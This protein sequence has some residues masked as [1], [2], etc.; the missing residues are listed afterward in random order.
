MSRWTHV[1][2]LIRV[3][4]FS[5]FRQQTLAD[6]YEAFNK[7]IP[8]GSEGPLKIEVHKTKQEGSLVFCN[9][10]IYGDLRDFGAE[11]DIKAV[12]RWIKNACEHL[13]EKAMWVRQAVIQI[14]DEEGNYVLLH[15]S[16]I[17]ND[18]EEDWKYKE[19]E[20]WCHA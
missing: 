8:T 18:W 5:L 2:G 17:S 19:G 20:R 12:I 13:E 1:S 6:V 15:Q 3:D 9:V 14:D 4:A 11:G 7:N 16:A 10:S